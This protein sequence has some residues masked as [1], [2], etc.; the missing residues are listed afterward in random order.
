MLR[1]PRFQNVCIDEQIVPFTGRCP[2]RQYVPRKPNPTGLKNFV[3]ATDSGL[4]LDFEVY[5]R[6]STFGNFQLHG[7][8]AGQGVGAVLRLIETLPT[9]SLLFCDRFFV[10]VPLILHL[11]EK[12]IYM[13]G[14]IS[15]KNVPIKFTDDAAM[16]R[17]GRGT[18]E[19]Y[20]LSSEVALVK[21]YDNKPILMAS[22]VY[23]IE[24][25]DECQRW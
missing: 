15:R 9:G 22:S 25:T 3:L 17:E 2:S 8:P 10:S 16:K 12:K 4:V 6:S 19:Q 20:T 14:T 23:G 11:R 7:K 18:A 21:W 1:L 13:T 5:Q 24:P